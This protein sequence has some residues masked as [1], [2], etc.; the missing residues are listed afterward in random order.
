MKIRRWVF[1]QLVEFSQTV[2]RNTR[3]I[4]FIKGAFETVIPCGMKFFAGSDFCGFFTIRKKNALTEKGPENFFSSFKCNIESC[5]QQTDEISVFYISTRCSLFHLSI[6]CENQLPED[7]KNTQQEKPVFYDRN[8][9]YKTKKFSCHTVTSLH[10]NKLLRTTRIFWESKGP[11]SFHWATIASVWLLFS[12][13]CFSAGSS[14]S[15]ET[16]SFAE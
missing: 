8:P 10:E 3:G 11:R 16:R 4:K 1:Q 14:I 15:T 6:A 2:T 7:C 13:R 9:K 12:Q 5:S